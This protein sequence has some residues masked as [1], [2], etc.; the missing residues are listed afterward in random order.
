MNHL[1]Y[2]ANGILEFILGM[3]INNKKPILRCV[4]ALFVQ[5]SDY[6][7]LH[8]I[9]CYSDP[10]SSETNFLNHFHTCISGKF[11]MNQSK[12]YPN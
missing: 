5:F 10:T 12:P 3:V 8:T 9:S 6:I 11:K 2:N 7:F 4:V 1:Q